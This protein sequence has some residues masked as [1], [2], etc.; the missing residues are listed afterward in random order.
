MS[1]EPHLADVS[2]EY[3][4]DGHLDQA[5]GAYHGERVGVLYPVLQSPE[6]PLLAAKIT[7]LYLWPP[8]EYHRCFK[9]TTC[10]AV[11]VINDD[12]ISV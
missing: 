1:Y 11:L 10:L 8:S 6:L 2:D 3:V 4:C 5:P 12:M 7:Q 9:L